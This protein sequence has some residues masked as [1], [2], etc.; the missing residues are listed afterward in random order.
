VLC[1]FCKNVNIADL[2]VDD[3][4]G[5]GKWEE[6]A[7]LAHQPSWEALQKVPVPVHFAL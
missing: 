7:G 5:T 4:P 3:V 1:D 6:S 2:A